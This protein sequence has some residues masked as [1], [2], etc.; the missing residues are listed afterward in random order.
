MPKKQ[1]CSTTDTHS[2]GSLIPLPLPACLF[3]ASA[4][5]RRAQWAP[6]A[7]PKKSAVAGRL[8][9]VPRTLRLVVRT[10]FLQRQPA[11][12]VRTKVLGCGVGQRE[13]GLSETRRE[14]LNAL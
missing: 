3:N 1:P 10:E 5:R 12:T 6:T 9:G 4:G 14:V 2:W 7:A 11:Q 13:A 8:V